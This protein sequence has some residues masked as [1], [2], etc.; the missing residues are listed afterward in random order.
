MLAVSPYNE[1]QGDQV[2]AVCHA[3]YSGRMQTVRYEWNPFYYN[4]IEKFGEATGV[5]IL[6]NID[7]P[8][9]QLT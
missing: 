2:K 1:P 4:L 7:L 3:G 9:T 8:D 6:L 5:P